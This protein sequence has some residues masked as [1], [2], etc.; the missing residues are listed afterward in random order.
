MTPPFFFVLLH[1]WVTQQTG[2]QAKAAGAPALTFDVPATIP[3][4]FNL[5]AFD[6]PDIGFTSPASR[7]CCALGDSPSLDLGDLP[8]APHEYQK[9]TTLSQF[10]PGG[11]TAGYVYT[12]RGGFIDLGHVRDYIDFTR[13]FASRFREAPMLGQSGDAAKVFNE[14]GDIHLMVARRSQRPDPVLAAIMG[15]KLAYDRATWHE[16][17]T[18][19]PAA[20]APIDQ[21]YSSFAPEDNFSNAVGVLAGYRAAVTRHTDFNANADREI[22]RILEQL[23]P[24]KKS[25]TARAVDYVKGFWWDDSILSTDLAPN[26]K[27]RNFDAISAVKPWLVTDIKVPGKDAQGAA[28]RND[29]GRPAPA[30]IAIPTHYN[31]IL[32]DSLARLEIT[33]IQAS[34]NA[35]RPIAEQSTPLKCS[36]QAFWTLV[37]AVRVKE[38]ST[39]AGGDSPGERV[40]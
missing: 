23:Q 10:V 21:K 39:N 2:D 33:N 38:V 28:L 40:P 11:G 36:T 4:V 18:Y 8:S 1:G 12:R 34:I 27:R 6:M 35:L 30:S 13:F 20:T 7:I 19:F 32:L 22:V 37:N 25:E 5:R 29:L 14:A 16:I 17:A 3:E 9:A 15:A 24:A 31:G 26:S